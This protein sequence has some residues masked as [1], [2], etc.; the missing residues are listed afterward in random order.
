[1]QFSLSPEGFSIIAIMVFLAL[2]GVN[3]YAIIAGFVWLIDSRV[4]KVS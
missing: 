1:M 4:Q 2:H 3:F